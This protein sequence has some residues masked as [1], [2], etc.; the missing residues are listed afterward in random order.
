MANRFQ[1]G[2]GL[3][4]CNDKTIKTISR[5]ETEKEYD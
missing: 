5:L 1:T 3:L 4:K 2:G